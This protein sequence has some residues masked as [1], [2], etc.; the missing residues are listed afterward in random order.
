MG[1]DAAMHN[2]RVLQDKGYIL[3]TLAEVKNR[4]DLII[5]AGTDLSSQGF[6]RFYERYL[7]NQH[8]MF[9]LDANDRDIVILE[10]V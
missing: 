10:R 6:D 1:S 9:D 3:T 8:S 5:F 4:A 7:W 2:Y